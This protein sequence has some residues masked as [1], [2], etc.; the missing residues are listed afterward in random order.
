MLEVQMF[1]FNVVNMVSHGMLERDVG[2][3]DSG[4]MWGV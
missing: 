2:C 3:C 1:F 4:A